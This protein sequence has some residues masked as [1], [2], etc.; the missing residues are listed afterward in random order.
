MGQLKT[1]GKAIDVT[2]PAGD[3]PFGDLF[4]IDGFTGVMM[5]YIAT[6]DTAR[7]AAMEI[8]ERV[9][10]VKT[11]AGIGS[12]RGVLVYWTAGAGTKR[13]DTDLTETATGSA[14]AK[15]EEARNT[16]GYAALRLCN[17]GA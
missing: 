12:A 17:T 5:D 7:G 9:W 11:P 13:G 4:R 16:N 1:D 2:V 6:A 8:S 3:Y 15:V 10:Y 14:V